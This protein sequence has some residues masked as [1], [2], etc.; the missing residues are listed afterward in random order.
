MKLLKLNKKRLLILFFIIAMG[1]LSY[2]QDKDLSWE[3]LSKQYEVPE[4][5]TEARFGIWVH[6][7]AQSVPEYG[8]GWYARHMYMQDVGRET[9]GKN[10]Y[11]YHL[12]RF[13]HPS[14][15]G[16]KDV[17]HE[18]KAEKLDTDKLL[19]YFTEDLGAKYFMALAHHHDNFDNWDSKNHEWNTVNVGP[20][21]DIIGEFSK[22]AKKY[23]VPFGVTTHNERFFDWMSPAFSADTSGVYKDIPYDGHLTKAEGK[24]TWWEGLDPA[25]LYGLPPDKRTPE[26]TE[27]WKANWLLR[28]QDLLTSYDID[29]VWFDGRGFPYGDYGKEAFRTFYNHN[30]EKY[31]KINAVIAGK[32]PGKDPGILHD[33]EQGVESEISEDPWQSICTFTHWFYKKDDP[34]RHDA[35]STIEL[36]V[37]VVSKNGNFVLNVELL[38][39]GT[40]PTEHKL[41]MDAF[42]NWLK[43]NAEAIYAT[44]PWQVHGDNLFSAYKDANETNTNL[45]NTDVV[46]LK[47]KSKQFNNRTKDSPP[48]GH[49][50]VR[51]TTKD[52]VLYMFVLN[53]SEGEITI[54]ALGL[55]SQYNPKKIQSI[56]MIG[57]ENPI[58]YNQDIR[59]LTLKIPKTRPNPYAVVF[60]IKGAL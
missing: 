49:N 50:E 2:A 58:Q 55:Q 48:Y 22:S 12:K 28:M 46:E 24:G 23:G 9:F 17:I 38:P 33:I 14:E 37:D 3:D 43:L 44:K 6:W 41:I 35:R 30:L 31:G 4:W 54:P 42:G 16:F 36:L 7:G 53:P 39:D 1:S 60:A 15:V 19:A 21:R 47:K 18:W 26:W 29:Y 45:A 8:G 10:A 59:N 51:F 20:K 13:G 11:P 27:A 25:L 52:G 40:I 32:I 56:S 57:N 5:F 34:S